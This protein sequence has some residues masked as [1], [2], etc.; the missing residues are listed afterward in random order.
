M[1]SVRQRFKSFCSRVRRENGHLMVTTKFLLSRNAQLLLYTTRFPNTH[2]SGTL[3]LTRKETLST[4]NLEQQRKI[5]KETLKLE[6]IRK[7]VLVQGY[8]GCIKKKFT[9]GKY[10]LN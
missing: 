6:A 8:T 4:E 5:A 3:S 10:F 9:V 7:E 1:P 2:N